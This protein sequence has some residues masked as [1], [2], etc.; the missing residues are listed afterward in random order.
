MS[1]PR[2]LLIVVGLAAAFAGG[3]FASNHGQDDEARPAINQPQQTDA[4]IQRV[5]AQGKLVPDGG[6]YNVFMPPGQLIEQL[7]V[8]ENDSVVKDETRLAVLRGADALQLQQQLAESQTEDARKEMDQKILAAEVQQKAAESSVATA[9]LRLDQ[10]R[11]SVDFSASEK[12]LKSASEKID[13]LK[14]LWSDPATQ[15]YVAVGAIAEQE[16][17]VDQ[18]RSKLD[19]ARRQQ[20]SAIQ[21]AELAR[22]VAQKNLEASIEQVDALKSIR[23]DGTTLRLTRQISSVRVEGA[24]IVS[25]IDG[26]VL[27]VFVKNGETAV[28]TPL[29][30]IGDLN[31]MQCQAEVVDRLVGDVKVGQSA[32]LNSPA[33]P[34]EIRATVI[35]IGRFVGSSTLA[36]P[37]PLALVDRKTVD[38]RLAI[39]ERD[40]EIAS[41]LVNLEVSVAIET[42]K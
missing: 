29:M 17:A 4:K 28:N 41:Q 12:Q 15:R 26:T 18:N 39:D 32:T 21:A 25:P 27:K 33:L 22:E 16:L 23:D 9:D 3:W 34:R 24:E 42:G 13:R 36:P 1:L 37:N 5:V 2:L 19:A 10:A 30:Q 8:R 6:I 11:Q 7:L 35:S 40:T 31:S 38:V 20:R 14:Q